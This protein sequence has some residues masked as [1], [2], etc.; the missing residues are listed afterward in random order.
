LKPNSS[1]TEAA[2]ER[3]QELYAANRNSY[4]TAL[5][6]LI[7]SQ[8]EILTGWLQRIADSQG[9]TNDH[10][11]TPTQKS[12]ART[13]MAALNGGPIDVK[14]KEGIRLMLFEYIAALACADK[15]CTDNILIDQNPKDIKPALLDILN[16]KLPESNRF[17][18]NQLDSSNKQFQA[19]VV[20]F[21]ILRSVVH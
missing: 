12:M 4:Q 17:S 19:A 6:S 15:A 18:G 14:R 21:E 13:Y 11:V 5:D 9:L 3:F 1:A 20:L 16:Q 10:S 2:T 8:P 7:E